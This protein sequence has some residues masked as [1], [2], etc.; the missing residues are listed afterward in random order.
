MYAIRS[1]YEVV[2]AGK[3]ASVG[4][5]AAGIAHEINNPVAI[6]MESAGWVQDLMKQSD[7][8]KPETQTEISETLKEIVIQGRR[9]KEITHKLLSFAR[10]TDSRVSEVN[11][12]ELLEEIVS[13]TSQK[14][15]FV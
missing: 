15:R 2:E 12:N 8:E 1:Y 4:E 9:C 6:M 11:V 14:A 5:L 3:L 7:M 13:L 10:R